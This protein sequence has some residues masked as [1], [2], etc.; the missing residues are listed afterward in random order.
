L[1]HFYQL[2]SARQNTKCEQV[3]GFNT[4]ATTSVYFARTPSTKQLKHLRN[5]ATTL[6]FLFLLLAL[7]Q[8]FVLRLQTADAP[9]VAILNTKETP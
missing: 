6:R 4:K 3:G 7:P 1:K 9:L 8:L 2:S 5:N